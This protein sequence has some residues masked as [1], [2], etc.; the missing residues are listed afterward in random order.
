MLD[1]GKT[2]HQYASVRIRIV[3]H[4]NSGR[5]TATSVTKLVA[6]STN[7]ARRTADRTPSPIES[8]TATARARTASSADCW[9][10]SS[11]SGRT[12]TL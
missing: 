11:T 8:G 9:R 2:G 12:G 6:W 5:E 1:G 3:P 10:R 7:R 4:T